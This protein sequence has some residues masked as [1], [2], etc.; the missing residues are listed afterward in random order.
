[1]DIKSCVSSS[2]LSTSNLFTIASTFSFD[3]ALFSALRKLSQ[4][5]CGVPVDTLSCPKNSIKSLDTLEHSLQ[6]C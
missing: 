6:I 4:P 2:A 5:L 1:M 3:Q